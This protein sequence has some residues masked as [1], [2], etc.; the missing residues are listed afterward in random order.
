MKSVPQT[1]FFVPRK[2]VH[3][4]APSPG[5]LVEAFTLRFQIVLDLSKDIKEIQEDIDM[6]KLV[7]LLY[8]RKPKY[9]VLG[10]KEAEEAE[11]FLQKIIGELNL[12][13]FGYLIALKG[14]ILL[15]LRLFLFAGIKE[16]KDVKPLSRTQAVFLR[17]SSFI[18]HNM[19][20]PI[21]LKEAASFCYVSSNY[22]QK[23]FKEFL[24]CS[25]SR[26]VHETKIDHAKQLLKT[27]ELSIKEIA[28]KCGI[29][30][31]NYFSRLFK[32]IE[33]CS[34]TEFRHS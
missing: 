8:V 6:T 23:I 30:D 10:V 26:Y 34:P 17:A 1:I 9:I 13:E 33:G 19:D 22:L 18:N 25:F 3:F 15:L 29:Y 24:G 16:E 11:I 27:T 2:S 7:K 14:H 20:Q 21:R 32:K 4:F 12:K 5:T 31:T 28:E